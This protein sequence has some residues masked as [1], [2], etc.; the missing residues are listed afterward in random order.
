MDLQKKIYN[1]ILDFW[2]L[3][4]FYTPAPPRDDIAKWDELLDQS[5]KMIDKHKT[6]T[7]EDKLFKDI[8][9]AWHDYVGGLNEKR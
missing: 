9:F 5:L 7:K 8:V 2:K 6:G 1:F 3:V 4:K